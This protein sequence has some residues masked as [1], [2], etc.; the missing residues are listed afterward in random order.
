MQAN[1]GAVGAVVPDRGGQ[2]AGDA[3][4]RPW[5]LCRG[6]VRRLPGHGFRRSWT[7]FRGTA[8]TVTAS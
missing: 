6:I 2:R 5:D 1:A 8:L 3:V 7:R 4:A